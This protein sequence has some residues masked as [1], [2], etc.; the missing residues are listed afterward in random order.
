MFAS[1][2]LWRAASV[3][4]ARHCSTSPLADAGTYDYVIVGAGT[5]GCVLANRLTANPRVNVALLEA[6]GEDDWIWLKIPVGYLYAMMNPRV[7]WCYYTTPQPGLGGRALPYPRGKVLGGC[8]SINGTVYM[9]GQRADYDEWGKDNPGWSWNDVLPYFKKSMDYSWGP[10]SLHGTGGEWRV[11]GPRVHWDVL[12]VFQRAAEENG[13]PRLQHFNCSDEEGCGPFQ[14][15]HRRGVR[16][17]AST[18]FLH[19]VRHRQ[20]LTVIT[21]AAAK[22]LLFEGKKAVGVEA[23]IEGTPHRVLAGREVI[24]T[25][26]A[27]AS[28]H[29]LQVSGVGPPELLKKNGVT[30]IHA[31]EGVGMNLHD[32]LQIRPVYRLK[33][34]TETLNQ[35]TGLWD[36]AKMGLQYLIDRRGP[37]SM[38]PSQFGAIARSNPSVPTP[39]LEFHVQPLSCTQFGQPLD[40]FPGMT[41]SVCDLRPTSRGSVVLNGPD[42]SVPPLIDPAYLITQEDRKKAADALRLVRK[43]MS[44]KAFEGLEP[45]E[46]TPGDDLKT[47]EELA[48]AAGRICSS[49][50]HPVST[51]RMGPDSDKGSVVDA[52]LKVKGMSSLRVVDASIMPRIVSGN[53]NSPVIMIAEKAAEMIIGDQ[54]APHWKGVL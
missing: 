3:H 4:T 25:A 19:P 14:V 39:D 29:L 33:E 32:H 1:R 52:A 18:A 37:L 20:N 21:R 30:P 28:P 44:S 23:D 31:L 12:N 49:I 53:T 11:E 17:S 26:G 5:A 16:C 24:L 13:I 45:V 46:H 51:C 9:R 8:S 47:D 48:E 43:L 36:K 22:R 40:P 54:S 35:K 6:G 50:F 7:D 10:D 2:R 38:A 42:V 15:N 34:G 27:I 41:L